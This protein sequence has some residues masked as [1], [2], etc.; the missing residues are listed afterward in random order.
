MAQR[1]KMLEPANKYCRAFFSDEEI[2]IL[3][4]VAKFVDKE[5]MPRRQDCEG[6]WHRN[7][8]LAEATLDELYEGLTKLG[9][10]RANIPPRFDGLGL[11]FLARLAIAEEISRGDCGL[12]TDFGKI[13]WVV[14]AM[15]GAQRDDLLAEMTPKLI[16]DDCWTACVAISE[17]GGGAN[18]E[19]PTQEGR[20][21]R[22][23]ARE[24]GDSY[25]LKGHKIWPGPAGPSEAF[26]REKRKGILGYLTVATTDPELGRDGIGLFWVPDG[27]PGMSFT[28]PF[29]KMGM[30]FSDRN[31]EIWYEDVRIP[32]KYRLAGPGKDA[33]ILHAFIVGAGR[34]VGGARCVGVAT[35][36]LETALSWTANR[37]IVGK[38]VRE[39]SM[40]AGILGELARDV[41]VARAY[42]LQ[43]GYCMSHP[44]IYGPQWSLQQ[45]ARCSAARSMAADTAIKVGNRAMELMGSYGY[46]FES[47]AEKYL[48]DIKIIQM[49]L[50][51]AQ[52]DRLDVALGYY[53]FSW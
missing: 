12:A 33:D 25:V 24:D 21:L 11:S 7:E 4:T 23:I 36:L 10:Q 5:V 41:E 38:P 3:E 39:R 1:Y 8:E 19:D 52:R 47:N 37:D 44:E 15:L 17:P 29:E 43:A 45:V 28:N 48:R 46:V 40:F 53:P 32:K 22:T 49:W 51:G 42:Y 14:G 13:H 30:A 6:G 16:G 34:L 9:V 18:I 26:Q 20:S 50:G 31:T 27:T 35:A 2:A